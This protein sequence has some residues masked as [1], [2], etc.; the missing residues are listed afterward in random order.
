MKK[1]SRK[2]GFFLR[3]VSAAKAPITFV[4]ERSIK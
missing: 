3:S 2:T 4:I 1:A